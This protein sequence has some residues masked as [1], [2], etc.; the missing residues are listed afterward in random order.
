[1]NEID[2]LPEHRACLAEL[3][4]QKDMYLTLV[5]KLQELTDSVKPNLEAMYAVKIGSKQLELL[6]KQAEVAALKYTMELMIACLNKKQAIDRSAIE[7]QVDEM[8][9]DYYAKIY[10]EAEQIVQ[11]ENRLAGMMTRAESLSMKK[12][13]YEAAKLLHP[14]V[15]P[16]QTAEQKQLW[17]VI[18][19]AYKTGDLLT[20]KNI[21]AVIAGL[22]KPPEQIVEYDALKKQVELFK[23]RNRHLLE[24]IDAIQLDFPFTF[25]EKLNDEA[26]VRSECMLVDRELQQLDET[27]KKYLDYI[28]LITGN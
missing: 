14:D 25:R 3:A 2:L 15:N 7:E 27:A 24:Q 19:Q 1:M 23:E 10:H 11:A 8:L 26:W 20:V 17:N 12:L 5:L 21:S 28:D 13:Y 4:T 9:E 6:R 18:S 16:N 22:A